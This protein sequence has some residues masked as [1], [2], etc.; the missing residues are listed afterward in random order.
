MNIV[1][2][3]A[4]VIHLELNGIS[5]AVTDTAVLLIQILGSV[6]LGDQFVTFTVERSLN[7]V[8]FVIAGVYCSSITTDSDGMGSTV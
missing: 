8:I 7:K 1:D 6:A 3:I 5:G 2:T 4:V